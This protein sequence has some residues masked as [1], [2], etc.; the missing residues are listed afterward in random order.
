MGRAGA[1]SS[2]DCLEWRQVGKGTK[3]RGRAYRRTRNIHSGENERLGEEQRPEN[4]SW[5]G[6]G[7]QKEWQPVAEPAARGS[8]GLEEGQ[9]RLQRSLWPFSSSRRREERWASLEMRLGGMQ[10]GTARGP[11]SKGPPPAGGANAAARG[12]ENS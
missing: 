9:C 7:G 6:A 12:P 3:G 2:L 4:V 10:Q 11:K 1:P 5:E 8:S